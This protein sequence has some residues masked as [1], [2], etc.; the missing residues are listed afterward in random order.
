MRVQLINNIHCIK[1]LYLFIR[2][3]RDAIE[4]IVSFYW[5]TLIGV[6]LSDKKALV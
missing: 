5:L 3:N 1:F 4:K 6:K 2:C